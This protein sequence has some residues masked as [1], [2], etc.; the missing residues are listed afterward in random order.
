MHE[1][2]GE[3]KQNK[4]VTCSSA[5]EA[6]MPCSQSILLFSLSL[7]GAGRGETEGGRERT[8]KRE[9]GRRQVSHCAQCSFVFPDSAQSE[10]GPGGGREEGQPMSRGEGSG[11]AIVM[12]GANLHML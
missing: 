2:G 8:K 6:F 11:E 12:H 10:G 9:E 5:S 1:G 3:K 4:T 7:G